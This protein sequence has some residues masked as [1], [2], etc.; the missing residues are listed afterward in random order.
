MIERLAGLSAARPRLVVGVWIAAAAVAGA[1][2]ALL[3][4]SALTSEGEMTN[5]PESYRAYDLI[6][7][8]LPPDP[9]TMSYGEEVVL[10]RSQAPAATSSCSNKW[11]SASRTRS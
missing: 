4:P 2:I 11:A 5:D 3:L 8:R 9:K 10:V 6:E 7:E 1:A